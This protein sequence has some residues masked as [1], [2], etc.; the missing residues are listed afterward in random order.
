MSVKRHPGWYLYKDT[1]FLAEVKMR[2]SALPF[3]C[4]ASALRVIARRNDEVISLGQS[5]RCMGY[6]RSW[7][8]EGQ[9]LC[10]HKVTKRLSAEMLLCA[11]GLCPAK[12]A[13]PRLLNLTPL[14][15]LIPLLRQGLLMPLQP[16]RPPLFCPLSPEAVLLT[17]KKGLFNRTNSIIH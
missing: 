16:H 10:S 11:L 4:G 6:T 1:K 8:R 7:P 2:Q 3:A 5:M 14:R 17:G 15:S 12:R 9:L 13:E